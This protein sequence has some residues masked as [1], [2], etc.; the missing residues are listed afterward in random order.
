LHWNRAAIR[1]SKRKED[2]IVSSNGKEQMERISPQSQWFET[3]PRSQ[4][5]HVVIPSIQMTYQGPPA[6]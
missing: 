6:L 5:V 2:V 1:R 3:K 4:R